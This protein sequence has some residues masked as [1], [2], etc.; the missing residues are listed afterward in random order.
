MEGLFSILMPWNDAGASS[1]M[2]DDSKPKQV[3]WPSDQ[4]A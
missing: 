4:K 3:Q 1:A 2:D